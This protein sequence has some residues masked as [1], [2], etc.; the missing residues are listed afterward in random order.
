MLPH[1]PPLRTAD[2]ICLQVSHLGFVDQLLIEQLQLCLYGMEVSQGIWAA[3]INDMHQHSGTLTMAKE[4]VPQ[5][6]PLMST[7]QQPC[8]MMWV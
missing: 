3:A 2:C 8:N 4:L 6:P 1:Q 7:F 5:A